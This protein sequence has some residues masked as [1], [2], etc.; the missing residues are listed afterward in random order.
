M[1][2]RLPSGSDAPA[3]AKDSEEADRSTDAEGAQERNAGASHGDHDDGQTARIV[4]VEE[5]QRGTVTVVIAATRRSPG[6]G[7]RTSATVA[8]R[9]FGRA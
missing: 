9:P 8:R 6:R 1:L 2:R 3:E 4:A 7:S 5:W